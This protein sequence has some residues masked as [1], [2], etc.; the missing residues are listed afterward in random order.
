[1]KAKYF[2][3]HHLIA[4]LLCFTLAAALNL[5]GYF[6]QPDARKTEQVIAQQV[7][8]TLSKTV[9]DLNRVKP[10]LAQDTL[11]FHDLLNDRSYYPTI[12]YKNGRPVFWTDH[13]VVVDFLPDTRNPGPAV[14]E[15]KFGKF[16]ISGAFYGP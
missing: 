14:V 15:N 4:A 16:L 5:Y 9:R 3:F 11:N 10:Y 12:I 1:M 8:T 6:G 7:Q 2:P 13:T